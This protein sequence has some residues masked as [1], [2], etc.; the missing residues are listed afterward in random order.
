MEISYSNTDDV[1][2]VRISDAPVIK[3]VSYGWNVNVGY[4]ADGQLAEIT[5]LDLSSVLSQKP[6]A[7][8][9]T[10]VLTARESLRLAELAEHPP[11]RS[12]IFLAGSARYRQR[13]RAEEPA[14]NDDA[15]AWTTRQVAL[16]RGGA[17]NEIQS[18]RIAEFFEHQ[19]DVQR[20]E[21]EALVRRLFIDQWKFDHL[22]PDESVVLR[23]R[24]FRAR[25]RDA[26]QASPS[27]RQAATARLEAI[28]REARMAL[29]HSLAPKENG[30]PERPETCPYTL[31]K[32]L[33]E[34]TPDEPTKAVAAEPD[35]AD[36][37][38]CSTHITP[39]GGNIFLDLGF[40]LDEA[41]RLREDSDRR[42]SGK[43]DNIE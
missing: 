11:Q 21:F 10:L 18:E 38:T 16:L 34:A 9:A 33:D 3:D 17:L 4:D 29:N 23:L 7:D 36:R 41:E 40:P 35:V 6:D 32:L 2:Y 30:A 28:W 15:H 39:V 31:E 1:L 19:A 43:N 27:L 24:E 26:L 42:M 25:T 22:A 13:L 8:E 20:Q 14:I 37:S 12:K 5:F